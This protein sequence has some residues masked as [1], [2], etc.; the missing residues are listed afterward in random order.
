MKTKWC[1]NGRTGEVFS[2]HI[3]EA[4]EETEEE[5]NDF[6][7]GAFMVYE[8]YL[9]TGFAS[10]EDAKA[11]GLEWSPC[12][13]CKSTRKGQPGDKCLSCGLELTFAEVNSK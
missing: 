5:T 3:Y 9:V 8:D 13:K 4:G 11:L 6:P 1:W 2:Y 12:L 10:E 7:R